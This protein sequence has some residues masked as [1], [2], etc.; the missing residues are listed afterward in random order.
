MNDNIIATGW[1]SFRLRDLLSEPLI[2]GRSVPTRDDGF[3]VLRLTAIKS[4]LIDLNEH[5]NGDWTEVQAKP[6]LVTEGDFLVSRGSGSLDFVGRGSPVPNSNLRIAFPD[7][8]IRVRVRPDRILPDF[9]AFV[10]ESP[11]VRSQIIRSVR[12]TSGIFKVNQGALEEICLPV[13]PIPV[14]R[15]IT[16]TLSAVDALRARRREAIALCDELV[17]ATF[18]EMFGDPAAA[19]SPWTSMPLTE[20]C[21]CYSGGTPPKSNK[22]NWIGQLPWF[23]AKDMKK[24]DLWRSRDTI[25]E[26]VPGRTSL[27]LLPENT[28]AIVVRGMILA[29]TFPV[30]ILRIPATINQDLKALIP[31]VPLLPEYLASCLRAQSQHALAQVSEAAHGTSKLDTEGLARIRILLPP[32]RLQA[33]FVERAKCI[34]AIRKQ[35]QAHL[36]EVD[37]LFDSLQHRAFHGELWDSWAA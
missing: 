30:C 18:L 16:Q 7:T 3:P 36:S 13:P 8:M 15:R 31:R 2:N 22:E 28:V 20:A 10:W 35:N 26:S 25:S 9:L 6:F 19:R 29:H 21:H 37:S 34:G 17:Q 5:K 27:K 4:S 32:K 33:Q 1:Q 23:S 11:T 14:Q 12:T 24:S